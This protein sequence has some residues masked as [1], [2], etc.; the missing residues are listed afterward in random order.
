MAIRRSIVKKS[1]DFSIIDKELT[2]EGTISSKGK[3]I[4]RG[5][6]KGILV[7]ETVIISKEGSVFGDIKADSITIGGTFDGEIRISRDLVVLS[8]G[9]CS[10]KVVYRDLVVEPGG[11]LNA[12]AICME[13]KESIQKSAD[14]VRGVSKRDIEN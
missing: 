1:N 3:L 7:G 8:T 11:I 2:V 10:G 14:P 6:V 5:S 9:R 4:I 13:G 12:Q